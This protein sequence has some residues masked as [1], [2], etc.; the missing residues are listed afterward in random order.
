MI[1]A[2]DHVLKP[3]DSPNASNDI[4]QLFPNEQP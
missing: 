2:E 4:V 3:L 1:G